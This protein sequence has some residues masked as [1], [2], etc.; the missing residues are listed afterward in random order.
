MGFIDQKKICFFFVILLAACSNSLQPSNNDS[1]VN[2]I[3]DNPYLRFKQETASLDP[4]TETSS[5]VAKSKTKKQATKDSEINLPLVRPLDIEGNINIAGTT[6]TMLLNQLIYDRFVRQGYSDLINFS[7]IGTNESIKLFCEEKKF[8]LLTL[9]R[10][11]QESEILACRDNGIEP[12]N[13][14]IGKDAVVIV[15]SSQNNFVNKVNL[16]MLAAIFT[17]EKWSDIN[18]SWPNK[19]IERFLIDSGASFDLV[20]EKVLAGDA[21]SLVNTSNTNLYLYEDQIIQQLSTNIYGISFLSNSVFKKASKSL[22]SLVIDGTTPESIN[23]NHKTYPLERSLYIYVD[24]NQIKQ[25]SQLSS[26][27]NFYLTNV[28][29]EIENAE[30]FPIALEELNK[31]KIKWLRVMEIKQ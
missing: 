17:K 1:E 27:V 29:E 16:S 12:I 19:S 22:K 18:S 5:I 15:V 25:N 20:A 21:S 9:A 30:L 8:D 14:L 13:F 2:A 28:N 23:F 4:L 24:R 10:P 7:M 31:S 3:K 6:G 26:F 11:M